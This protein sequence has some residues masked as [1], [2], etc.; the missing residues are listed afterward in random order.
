[1]MMMMMM[2]E[3]SGV[4]E[5][6]TKRE[7][8]QMRECWRGEKRILER[9][10]ETGIVDTTGILATRVHPVLYLSREL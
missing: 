1:M 4:C 10:N 6:E 2:M 7:A 3:A 9:E 8:R 5:T